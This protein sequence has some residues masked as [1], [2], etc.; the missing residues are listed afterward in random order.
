MIDV[1]GKRVL[2]VGLGKSG[3]AALEALLPLGAL[4]A[5]QDT[6]SKDKLEP[7]L[8]ELIEKNKMDCYLGTEPKPSERFD[9]I[10]L[11]PG[12]PP[13][14]GFIQNAKQTGSEIIGELELAFQISKGKLVAITGTN[15]KT[16]T[17]A[18][19]GEIFKNAGKDTYVAGNIGLAVT[20]IA[21]KTKDDSWIIAETSSFQLETI[22]AFKPD[23]SAFLNIS[24]DHL[25]RYGNMPSYIEAKARIF[26]NQNEND[27]FIVNY[28]DK[29][30]YPLASKCKAKVVPFSRIAELEFGTF[31]KEGQIVVRNEKGALVEICATESLLIPGAH[32]LENALAA[33]AIAYVAGIPVSVIAQTLKMFA[34]VEH[35]LEFCRELDGVKF[36]ND[37]KGT[38]TDASLKAIE[39]VSGSIILIAGGYDKN[40]EFEEW[41]EAFGDKVKHMVLLGDTAEKIK[42]AA[43]KKGF[44]KSIILKDMEEC[45]KTAFELATPGDTVLLSPA[46]ASWD[47]YT[48]FEERGEHF[49]SCAMRLGS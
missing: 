19:V 45:V 32:N 18:L 40:S 42:K 21:H 9:M 29:A 35:R 14:L 34:G 13:E 25:D 20:S 33:T 6:K 24:P 16:T 7:K 2:V 49:K 31:V 39:A 41:I 30:I 44:H 10:V 47:M 46:C 4:C 27:Y 37:S 23:I 8:L 26:E 15:G 17:T 1:R 12:V 22:K 43:E 38:N 48:C 11:S 36:V 5:V 28:D 3:V